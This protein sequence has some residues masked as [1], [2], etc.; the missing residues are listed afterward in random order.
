MV[1]DILTPLYQPVRSMHV[2]GEGH[3]WAAPRPPLP[4]KQRTG[5]LRQIVRSCSSVRGPDEPSCRQEVICV[6]VIKRLRR[7]LSAP[8]CWPPWDAAVSRSRR[9]KRAPWAAACWVPAPARSL[10]PPSAIPRGRGDRRRNR[11]FGGFA[12]GNSIQNQQAQNQQ[13]QIDPQQQQ[14]IEAQRREM[15]QMRQQ[16]QTE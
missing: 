7:R 6:T 16:Q 10:A 2:F 13:T 8:S 1:D 12:V 5:Q 11:R 9:V 15:E 14:E 4:C 3:C